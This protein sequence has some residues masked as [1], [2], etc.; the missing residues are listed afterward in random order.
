MSF[1]NA[2]QGHSQHA[3]PVGET[4]RLSFKVGLAG[5]VSGAY[6]WPDVGGALISLATHKPTTI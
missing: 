3:Y 4:S 6:F 2:T 1:K 5:G